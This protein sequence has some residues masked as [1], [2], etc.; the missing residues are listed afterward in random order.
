MITLNK[1][2]DKAASCSRDGLVPSLSFQLD[3]NGIYSGL[4]CANDGACNKHRAGG[5]GFSVPYL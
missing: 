4:E 1:L 5:V 2:T 3:L